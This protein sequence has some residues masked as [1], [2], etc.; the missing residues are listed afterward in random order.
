LLYKRGGRRDPAPARRRCPAGL[1][2]G[3]LHGFLLRLLEREADGH[4]TVLDEDQAADLLD[5]CCTEH[6]YKGTVKALEDQVRRG[7]R[8]FTSEDLRKPEGLVASKFFQRLRRGQMVTFDTI[9]HNG[10]ALLTASP[11]LVQH[12]THLFIDEV[13]DSSDVD[14]AIYRLLQ[15][16]NKFLVGDVDQTIFV[17]RGAQVHYLLDFAREPC[18]EL[19]ELEDNYRC[20]SAI[21]EA[22]QRLIEH[23]QDR[24]QKVTRSATGR[25][26]TVTVKSFPTELDEMRWL[27]SALIDTGPDAAV[28]LR[29]KRL[30]AQFRDFLMGAGIVCATK[31]HREMPAD[32]G[33]AK[34]TLA[35]LNDPENDQ[36]ASWYV[37][38]QHGPHKAKQVA[39]QANAAGQTINQAALHLDRTA[40]IEYALTC[41]SRAG[42]SR[43]IN[44]MVGHVTGTMPPDASLGDAILALRDLERD[45]QVGEGITVSTYHGA[46][47]KEWGRSFC[48][49][50]GRHLTGRG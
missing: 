22:A 2:S 49:P 34:L 40:T 15:I 50:R 24:I 5:E 30:V 19:I 11:G 3:T 21:C 42:I 31:Q 9:L 13:Q 16:P 39:L 29:T 32:W 8:T 47:G 46:K 45:E 25:T 7:P 48:Q 14:W 27:I 1:F 10:L 26:G 17:W 23:N 12:F 6:H 36:L 43:R 4:L 38:H 37:A 20:G 18:V 41:M 28:L 33:L 44:R 35:L